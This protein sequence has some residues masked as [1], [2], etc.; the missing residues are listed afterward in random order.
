M[1]APSRRPEIRRRRTRNEKIVKLR[2]R[3]AA[4]STEAERTRI[5]GKLQRMAVNSPGQP[6]L[7]KD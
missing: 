5:A 3:H 1:S 4:A 6:L 7:K 2:K